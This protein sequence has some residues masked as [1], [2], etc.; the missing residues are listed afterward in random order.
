[1]MTDSKESQEARESNVRYLAL[2]HRELPNPFRPGSKK[3]LCFEAFRCGGERNALIEAMTKI[4][5]ERT[6]ARTWLVTFRL[7]ARAH[8]DAASKGSV[9]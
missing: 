7:Y 1:M 3:F 2:P 5:V 8:R 9:K 4:G 6:T